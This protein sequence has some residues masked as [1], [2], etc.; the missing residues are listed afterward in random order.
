MKEDYSGLN[1][2]LCVGL[3]S[4]GMWKVICCEIPGVN[5]PHGFH[6]PILH[7]AESHPLMC[8]QAGITSSEQSASEV[9]ESFQLWPKCQEQDSALKLPQPQEGPSAWSAAH[10]ER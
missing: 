2:T 4:C 10:K 6:H 8:H 9:K 3:G 5:I 1:L 7:S